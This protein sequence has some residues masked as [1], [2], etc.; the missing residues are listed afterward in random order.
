[1]EA[2]NLEQ[3]SSKKIDFSNQDL[4]RLIVPLVVEQ[5]L[6]MFVGIAD[7]MMV[8]NAGEAAV[9]GVALVDMINYLVIVVL[10][11]LDTGGAVIISQ[12]LGKI[13][14]EKADHAASQLLLQTALISVFLMVFCLLFHKGLIRLFFGA[15]EPDAN[16]AAVTYFIIT[17]M[18]FPFLGFYNASAAIF[19]SMKKTNVTMKI[20]FLVNCINIIGNAIGI[21]GFRAGVMG[22]AIP[23]LIARVIG[24]V[25]MT[26]LCFSQKNPVTISWSKI[27]RWNSMMIRKIMQIAVPNGIENGLFTLGRVLVTSI[28]AL[29]GTS[30]IAANGVA[31]SIDQIALTVVNANNLAMVTVVGQCMGAKDPESA[32]KYTKKLMKISYISTTLLTILVCL[33]LPFIRN[34]YQLSDQTWRTTCILVISHNILASCLHPTSFNLPSSLRASGDAKYTMYCGIISMIVFR[35]GTAYL[36]GILLNLGVYGVWVAMGMDWL[37][38]SVMFVLRYRKGK[39]RNIQ[40][41]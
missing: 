1:M 3:S 8:S 4:K 15:I 36:F 20:A 39:W 9:S 27:C 35:L 19:R 41:V 28:V 7:T 6:V 24:A 13:N 31:F 34:F 29:F 32:A 16:N 25:I 40:L 5:T 38:R 33:L 21:Y 10:A 26:A 23:T 30:Q 12:Y 37:A 17:A 22:V 2:L 11:A 14:K 18:S